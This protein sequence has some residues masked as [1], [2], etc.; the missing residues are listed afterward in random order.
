M[1]LRTL[2]I[3]IVIGSAS[4]VGWCLYDK[5]DEVTSALAHCRCAAHRAK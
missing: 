1:E 3:W 5:P 4:A 2:M